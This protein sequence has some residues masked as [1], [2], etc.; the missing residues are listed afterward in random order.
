VCGKI[1]I[2]FDPFNMLSVPIP[3]IKEKTVP[4]KFIP[5]SLQEKPKIYRVNIGEYET[6]YELK[7]KIT[8]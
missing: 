6:I 2:S 8:E 7:Q 4:V 3:C 5:A 1:S